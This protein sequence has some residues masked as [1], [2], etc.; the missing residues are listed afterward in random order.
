MPGFPPGSTPTPYPPPFVAPGSTPAPTPPR[1][2][3]ENLATRVNVQGGQNDGIAG[4]IKRHTAAKRILI[5]AVG[6]SIGISGALAD[7]VLRV[8]N[9]SGQIATN[10]DWRSTQQAEISASGLAPTNDKESALIINLPASTGNT[11]FTA[12]LSSA[13]GGSG[14]GVIEVYDLDAE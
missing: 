9:S 8:F 10:D 3:L 2:R 7:P 6:P 12:I 13:N 1:R 14:I 5:R 11:I 4:F